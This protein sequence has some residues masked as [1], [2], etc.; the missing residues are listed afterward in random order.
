MWLRRPTRAG[1]SANAGKANPRRQPTAANRTGEKRRKTRDIEYILS[2]GSP[3]RFIRR[4]ARRHQLAVIRE[5]DAQSCPWPYQPV[6]SK[7]RRH[8]RDNVADATR[9]PGA[10]STTTWR[11]AGRLMLIEHAPIVRRLT[12]SRPR[13]SA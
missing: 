8:T 4:R 2:Q 7:L 13:S 11:T 6:A 3:D 9:I 12:F 1:G 10:H 5:D